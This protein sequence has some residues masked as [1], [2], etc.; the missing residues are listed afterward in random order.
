MLWHIVCKKKIKKKSTPANEWHQGTR[1][2]VERDIEISG[3]EA[4]MWNYSSRGNKDVWFFFFFAL[5]NS[6][7]GTGVHAV[8]STF[9]NVSCY[10]VRKL[11]M[12]RNSTNAHV[13]LFPSS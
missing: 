13:F 9:L 5:R 12:L 7:S 8:V 4:A 10:W 1:Q 3:R 2:V 6:G 11:G